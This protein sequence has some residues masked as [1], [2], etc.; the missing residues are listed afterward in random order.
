MP[1]ECLTKVTVANL[2]RVVVLGIVERGGGD[3]VVVV[4]V[5]VVVRAAARA[6]RARAA[7][8]KGGRLIEGH[9]FD[10]ERL[11]PSIQSNVT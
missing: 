7:T 11:L 5:V 8:P 6:A 3:R 2:K 4:V 9:R 1:C 10:E